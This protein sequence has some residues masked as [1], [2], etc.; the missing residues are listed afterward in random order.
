MHYTEPDIDAAK[1]MMKQTVSCCPR[2]TD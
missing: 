1:L 2:R